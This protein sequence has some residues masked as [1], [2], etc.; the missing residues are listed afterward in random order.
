MKKFLQRSP[1]LVLAGI[2]LGAI[3]HLALQRPD[4]SHWIWLATLIA[5]GLPIVYRTTK[6]MLHGIFAS[7][8]V[9]MLA[10]LTAFFLGQAFAGS[11]VVLMQLG[12][13]AIEAYGL[14]R[15]T[16]SLSALLKRA[17]RTAWRKKGSSMEEIDVR[18]VQIGD[19][20]IVRPG[21]LI[22]V[23][24]T[25]LNGSAEIDESAIT[26]E[27]LARS[28][29]VGEKLLSGSIDVNGAIEMRADRE[30]KES[31]Y[32]KIVSLVKTA[33]E[34][35]APIQRLADRYAVLF[36]PLTLLMAGLG[37]FLTRDPSTILSVLVVATPCPLILATPLAVICGINRAAD[38]GIIVKGGAPLEQIASTEAVLFDKTGTITFGM[39]FVEE[40]VS[41]NGEAEEEI[42][43]HAAIIDQYSSHSVAKAI[44]SKAL[45]K[46]KS[47]PLPKRFQ[48]S[49]GRGVEGEINGHAYCIGSKAFLEEKAGVGILAPYQATIQRYQKLGKLLIFVVKDGICLGFL[50]IA[51]RI[52]PEARETMQGLR[53]LGVKE[54]SMVTG[55]SQWNAEMI[56]KE[57]GI[58]KVEAE[59]LP[60]EKVAV[61][62]D[63]GKRYRHVLMVGDGINDAPALATATV[64]VA[65]GAY[66]TAISA[67][68]ADIVLLVDDLSKIPDALSIGQ[69][70]LQVAKQSIW[71][72]LGLSFALMI[73]AAA[74][75]IIPAIG[76]MLQEI[77][78]V[79]VI[80]NA[81][82]ARVG[83]RR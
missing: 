64:G 79:A 53:S 49:P 7:D 20:L 42:L 51:D 55:D 36:T 40:V 58:A 54:I 41:L 34:E 13:E 31:Q 61:V 27:P 82:R 11:V 44:C 52:R 50:T 72:G 25:I 83:P 32:E 74:G 5:G 80:L 23:D 81:L 14:R 4:L 62:Q 33:Q 28:K 38:A 6:G 3:F 70:M 39:P 22:P 78:D 69:R 77:I 30:S 35:K 68:A 75:Y 76:A 17:P 57:A 21:D 48:E 29:G 16:S 37:F 2:L 24:G 19:I 10:I 63:Y 47:L 1:L 56:A 8:I 59:L 15:A 45:Q 43:L 60:E 67:E 73:V 65:M 71:I 12:G 66:G 9:A 26:G 18:Q 46:H